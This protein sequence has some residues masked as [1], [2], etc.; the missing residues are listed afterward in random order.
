[1]SYR[2]PYHSVKANNVSK[3]D[4]N[5]DNVIDDE[6]DFVSSILSSDESIQNKMQN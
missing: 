1:M 6:D 2:E 4:G 5:K 3:L